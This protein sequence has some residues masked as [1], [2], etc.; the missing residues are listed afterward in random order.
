MK[1]TTMLPVALILVIV[2]L[3]IIAIASGRSNAPNVT[4]DSRY[5]HHICTVDRY[6]AGTECTRVPFSFVVY[7]EHENGQPRLELSGF[8]PIASVTE[9]PDG[10][11]F[12]S[13]GGAIAGTLTV[14]NDRGIDLAATSG[15]GENLI[16]H[17]ASGRCERLKTP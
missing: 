17:Y 7:L 9:I 13:V 10:L 12:E 1:R 8:S 4:G 11:L 15:E 16:E 3:A 2:V 5:P 14:F 6:C